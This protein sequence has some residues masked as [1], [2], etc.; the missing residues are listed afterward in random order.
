MR[1]SIC[2]EPCPTLPTFKVGEVPDLRELAASILEARVATEPEL[3]IDEK[4]EGA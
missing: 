3:R 4:M 1:P 2:I